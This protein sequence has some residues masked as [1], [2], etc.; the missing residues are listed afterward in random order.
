MKPR[1]ARR[2]VVRDMQRRAAHRREEFPE[3]R[4]PALSTVVDL[5]QLAAEVADFAGISRAEAL[6]KVRWAIEEPEIRL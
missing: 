1:E 6:E 2:A 4:E 5:E 3:R